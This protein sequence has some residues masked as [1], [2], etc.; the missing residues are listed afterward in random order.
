MRHMSPS[1]PSDPMGGSHVRA[2]VSSRYHEMSGHHNLYDRVQVGLSVRTSQNRVPRKKS[3][4]AGAD[5]LQ[6]FEG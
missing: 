4:A 6:G 2:R 5:L 1:S 3:K